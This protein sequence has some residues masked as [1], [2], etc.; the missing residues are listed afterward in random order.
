MDIKGTSPEKI[1]ALSIKS[2]LS[3]VGYHTSSANCWKCGKLPQVPASTQEPAS[4]KVLIVESSFVTKNILSS[5]NVKNS[6]SGK[7]H[8]VPASTQEPASTKV[9]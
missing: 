3:G 2:S 9:F 5:Y 6:K 4:T 1:N 7:L 8:Q